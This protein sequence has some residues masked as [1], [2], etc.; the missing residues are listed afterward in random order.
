MGTATQLPG[1]LSRTVSERYLPR[2]DAQFP[3]QY[4]ASRTY[5]GQPQWDTDR[6]PGL[7]D[8]TPRIRSETMKKSDSHRFIAE[9]TRQTSTS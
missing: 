1:S 7:A 3:L 4:R 2:F 8:I 5:L 6:L 9:M